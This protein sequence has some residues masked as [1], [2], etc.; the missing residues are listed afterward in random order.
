MKNFFIILA[1][2]SFAVQVSW[3]QPTQGQITKNKL[4]Q[5]G[6]DNANKADIYNAL[7]FYIKAWEKDEENTL[8]IY[9]V[10][11]M[12]DKLRDYQSAATWYKRLL[13][14]DTDNKYP[15][16]RFSYAMTQKLNGAYEEAIKE[17][18]TF[19]NNYE[20]EKKAYFTKRANLEIEGARYATK[21]GAEP[22]ETLLIENAGQIINSPSTEDGPFPLGRDTILYSS[23]YA[24]SL[25]YVE[26]A[27]EKERFAR[28]YKSVR[29]ADGKEWEKNQPFQPE[30]IEREGFHTVQPAFTPDGKMMYFVRVQLGGN[31]LVNSRIYYAPVVDGK[32]GK[33]NALSF[34]S[35]NYSCKNPKVA[36]IG[37]T[38]YLLFASDMEGGEGGWDIWYV[39]IKEDG[40]TYEP[41]NMGKMV[42]TFVDEITPY[43]D[44]RENILYFSSNGHP[45]IGGMDIFKSK[46][47]GGGME[48][49]ETI[50][51]MGPGFNTRVDDFGFV[52]NLIGE[53]DC[54]GYLVSNRPGTISLKSETCCDDI[55][56]VFMP[57]RCDIRCIVNVK[58]QD[59]G[60]NI[61]GATVKVVDKATGDVVDART[62]SEESN[63]AFSLEQGKEYEIRT[64]K[65]GFETVSTTEVSTM[66]DALGG[67]IMKPTTI[68]KEVFLRKMGLVVDVVDLKTGN[69][70]NGA[71]VYVMD[72]NGKEVARKTESSNRFTFTIP[73]TKDYK[74]RV[75]K[76]GFTT[77]NGKDQVNIAQ[78]DLGKLQKLYIY[79]PQFPVLVN[80]LFDFDKSNIRA[81]AQ[82]ILDKVYE[83][84]VKYP[85]TVIEV[86]G[87]TDSKG[88]NSYNDRLSKNRSDA[89]IDYL[90]KKGI[91]KSRLVPVWKGEI[92]PVQKNENADGT[93][94]PQNRQL[95]RRVEFIIKK[96][97][98]TSTRPPAEIRKIGTISRETNTVKDPT[99]SK[100]TS[101][102]FPVKEMDLGSHVFGTSKEFE[103]EFTNTG[104]ETLNILHLQGSC[105]C[106]EVTSYTRKPIAPGAKG[107]IEFIFKSEYAQ[108]EDN[109]TTGIEIYGNLPDGVFLFPM[110]AD[111]KPKQ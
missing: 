73:R 53:D 59:S 101:L 25:I 33:P 22:S 80:I 20:G 71:T 64:E 5:M 90:V 10:A 30:A 6:D 88:S 45:S 7:S 39:E 35:E 27:E 79:A 14:A 85:K 76:K 15:L 57:E 3:T 66:P 23:L 60:E 54:S 95:N 109:Y 38:N 49:W 17:F 18:T 28:I 42:N 34:N 72:A 12:H 94:N 102:Q 111:I 46:H 4:I 16:V 55:F 2:F 86:T 47:S 11:S 21:I 106:T 32:V 104:S 107:K 58:N 96:E 8:A 52:I 44:P 29:S 100:E 74:I 84:L 93:D 56:A 68:D 105:T 41:I 1:L 19:V 103:I 51:N 82:A 81:D 89:A 97:D 87:H 65:G 37:G 69:A 50:T 63:F 31:M 99:K 40:T 91:S 26:E 61:L 43:F 78:K 48:N 108:V 13:D 67:P 92:F 24:D 36:T 9:K 62:N 77:E 110:T 83:V 70:V 98:A 75:E